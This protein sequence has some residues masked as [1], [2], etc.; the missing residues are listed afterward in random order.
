MVASK[1]EQNSCGESFVHVT[2]DRVAHPVYWI[3]VL[4]QMNAELKISERLDKIGIT[5]YV[6]TQI[7]V[8]Q[9]SDRKK[10][11]RRVVIPMI[12]F[13]LVD[14][15]I[16]KRLRT[17]SFIYKLLSYPGQREAA[18]IPS[19]QID[20][21]KFMLDNANAKVEVSG[22]VYQIGDKVEIVRGPLKGLCGELCYCKKD[23]PTLGVYI[24]LLGYACVSVSK[25]DVMSIN[26]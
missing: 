20:R 5:N 22:S 17:Y 6:P 3:A 23:K 21:L 16:E 24:E 4:V 18:K 10:Q 11:I 14:K 26:K 12:I 8:H 19:A 9:W 13:V 15:E 7:E 1:N 2:N 25:N